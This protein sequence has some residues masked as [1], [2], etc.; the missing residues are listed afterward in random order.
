MAV[1]YKRASVECVVSIALGGPLFF[2][3]LRTTKQTRKPARE[4]GLFFAWANG[5]D[6]LYDARKNM[7]VASEKRDGNGSL[8]LLK[9]GDKTFECVRANGYRAANAGRLMVDLVVAPRG[10]YA[11]EVL[12]NGFTM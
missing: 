11:A 3:R 4:G 10:V 1:S 5:I 6:L 2:G 9:K 8:G 12:S 7:I